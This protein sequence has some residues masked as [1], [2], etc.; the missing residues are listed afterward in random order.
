MKRGHLY[1]LDGKYL[2]C[3]GSRKKGYSNWYDV[4][5][6]TGTICKRIKIE[7]WYI[8]SIS[9]GGEILKDVTLEDDKMAK[10][11][12]NWDESKVEVAA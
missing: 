6:M 7:K 1:L 4:D 9:K 10:F 3:K 11:L 8:K 2:L 5:V 12:L